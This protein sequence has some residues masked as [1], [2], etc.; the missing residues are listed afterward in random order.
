MSERRRGFGLAAVL[1]LSPPE[2]G[3]TRI[4]ISHFSFPSPSH[5]L[6]LPSLAA[7]PIHATRRIYRGYVAALLVFLSTGLSIWDDAVVRYGEFAGPLQAG[8]YG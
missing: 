5:A 4:L 6:N 1:P 7:R 8:R 3:E 2:G